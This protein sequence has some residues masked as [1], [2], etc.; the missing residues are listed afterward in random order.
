MDKQ[1]I[2]TVTAAHVSMQARRYTDHEVSELK[3]E[4]NTLKVEIEHGHQNETRR[5]KRK[6]V[7]HG[8]GIAVGAGVTILLIRCHM[9]P[10]GA[11]LLGSLPNGAVETI[12][13]CLHI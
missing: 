3:A 5:I 13:R 8:V 11:A 6:F 10:Y 7:S 9:T 4:I 12:D 2:T 1:P